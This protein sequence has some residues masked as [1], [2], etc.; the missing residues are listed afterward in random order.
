[1]LSYGLDFFL[2]IVGVIVGFYRFEVERGG[3]RFKF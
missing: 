3:I 2:R 1:M